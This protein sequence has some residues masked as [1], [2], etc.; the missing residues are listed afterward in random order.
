MLSNELK[1]DLVSLSS[2][3]NSDQVMSVELDYNRWWL[4]SHVLMLLKWSIENEKET[5]WEHMDQELSATPDA[6]SVIV[7]GY[8]N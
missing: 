3:P 5:F 4:T 8:L 7:G 6:E 1:D 2:R